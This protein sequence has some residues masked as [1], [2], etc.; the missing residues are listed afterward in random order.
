MTTEYQKAQ[1][2]IAEA[3][4]ACDALLSLAYSQPRDFTE[5]ADLI[6][7]AIKHLSDALSYYRSLASD[8]AEARKTLQN[9]HGFS[10]LVPWRGLEPP[11]LSPLVPETSASTKFR[12]QGLA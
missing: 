5:D 4:D 2:S 9:Q 3:M 7:L 12:H 8:E 1:R 10:V 6:R 11:R